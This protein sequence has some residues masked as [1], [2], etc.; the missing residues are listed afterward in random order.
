MVTVIRDRV[1]D[2]IKRGKTLDQIKAA[3]LTK[4]YDGRYG[5]PDRFLEAAYQSLRK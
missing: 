5:S 4:D 2:Q 1:Q 3:G